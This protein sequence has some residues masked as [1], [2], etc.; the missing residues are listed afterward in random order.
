MTDAFG[1]APLADALKPGEFLPAE[2]AVKLLRFEFPGPA[3]RNFMLGDY[4][5]Y[6][7]QSDPREPQP[8]KRPDGM[9]EPAP[10]DL[11]MGPEGSGKTTTA[12]ATAPFQSM[13]L[14]VCADGVIRAKG[15]VTRDNYR[16]LQR[17]T[18]PSWFNQFPKDLPGAK[19]EGGQDRPSRYSLRFQPPMR[20]VIVEMEVDFFGIG[21]AAI[22]ELL[23]GYE[24]S[25]AYA[26]EADLQKAGVLRFLY[27]RTG[28]YPPA[29]M[30]PADAQ[31]LIA[32]GRDPRPRRV[33]GTFN[34]TDE[35]HEYHDLL[36]GAENKA[37]D[38][39][40][41][42]HRQP[43]GLSDKAENRKGV[44]RSKYEQDARVRPAHEVRRF[45]HGDWG[46]SKDG[47]LVFPEFDPQRHIAKKPIAFNPDFPLML[48]IDQGG[49]P[50]VIL[51]QQ[52]ARRQIVVLDEIVFDPDHV[53]GLRALADTLLGLLASDYQG[54]RVTLAA[55]DP[56]GFTGADTLGGEMAWAQMLAS[57]LGIQIV[58]CWTNEV[59][60]RLESVRNLLTTSI[61][62]ETPAILISPRCRRLIRGF[63]SKYVLKKVMTPRGEKV[64]PFKNEFA[65]VQDALQ[66]ILTAFLGRAGI[67]NTAAKAGR[68]GE[69]AP[70]VA[71]PVKL[72]G[73]FKVL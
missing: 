70:P 16:S 57:A 8:F 17:T 3:A 11:L 40:F 47:Q 26:D 13:R 63:V 18:L 38:P 54:A 55:A 27:G 64:R 15:V 45:V 68:P 5:F 52:I 30:L 41:R 22:E 20:D 53:T 65:D 32:A 46:W 14:P 39:F 6:D 43:S 10:C 2:Q 50:A 51:M 28:R 24:P 42:L 12:I 37:P 49:R 66:Y 67:L 59:D 58:P 35:D 1:L 21:D 44:S 48:G 60:V 61:D 31:K 72:K 62:A 36:M 23:K 4:P 9:S 34:P 56:A 7:P 19:F 33:W 25:W 29:F 73:N 69:I 71:G